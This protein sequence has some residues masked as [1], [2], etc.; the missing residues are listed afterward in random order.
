MNLN[1]IVMVSIDGHDVA[2]R[3][4]RR[5]GDRKGSVKASDLQRVASAGTRTG[6]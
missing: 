2:I 5:E 3:S 6:D 4:Q 1:D